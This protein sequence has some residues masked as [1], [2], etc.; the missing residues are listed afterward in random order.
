MLLISL[1]EL[2]IG[3]S[4]SLSSRQIGFL[5]LYLKYRSAP[6]G[7]SLYHL[8]AVPLVSLM[9]CSRVPARPIH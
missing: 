4:R 5:W 6:G 3:S 1:Y 9:G 8:A 2:L 7:P